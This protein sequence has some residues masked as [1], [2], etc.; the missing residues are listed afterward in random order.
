[1][2]SKTLFIKTDLLCYVAAVEK[3]QRSQR[4]ELMLLCRRK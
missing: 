4:V 3:L 1:V 2:A